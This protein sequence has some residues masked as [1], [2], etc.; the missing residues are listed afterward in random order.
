VTAYSS[1]IV[2]FLRVRYTEDEQRARDATGKDDDG[3]W[4]A[5]CCTVNG[6]GIDIYDEGGHDEYQ[7]RHIAAWNPAR[8]LRA[9][10][11]KRRIIEDYVAAAKNLEA[12]ERRATVESSAGPLDFELQRLLITRQVNFAA[13][14]WAVCA[15]AS[16]FATHEDYQKEWAI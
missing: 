6:R 15:L 10:G 9:V 11:A 4:D 8:V 1:S 5:W 16:E 2:E 13:L 14:S 12:T 7:A 3:V